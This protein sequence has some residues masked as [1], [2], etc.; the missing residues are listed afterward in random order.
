MI[1]A[2]LVLQNSEHPVQG[3]QQPVATGDF[4]LAGANW[5]DIKMFL[6]VAAERSMRAAATKA[7]VSVNTVRHRIARLEGHIG[8][9]LVVRGYDGVRLTPSGMQLEKA[10]LG[11]RGAA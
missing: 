10:A 9:P 11:M 1:A 5:D 2:P 6:D 4:S 8:E 7:G 3:V